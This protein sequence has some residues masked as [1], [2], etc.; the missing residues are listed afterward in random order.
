MSTAFATSTYAWDSA[1][2]LV[3]QTYGVDLNGKSRKMFS[4]VFLVF[5]DLHLSWIDPY[6]FW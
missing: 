2:E 6:D 5:I 3:P 4:L 1:S